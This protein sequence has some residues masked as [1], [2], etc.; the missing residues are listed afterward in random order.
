MR[1]PIGFCLLACKSLACS[2]LLSFPESVVVANL[3]W[4]VPEP[5]RPRAESL[6]V[7]AEILDAAGATVASLRVPYAPLPSTAPWPDVEP[8]MTIVFTDVPSGASRSVRASLREGESPTA[9]ACCVGESP[10]FD[11]SQ[12]GADVRVSLGWLPP[13]APDLTRIT[14]E[15]APWGT[16][17]AGGVPGSP[18]YRVVGSA[19]AAPPG[20]E[21]VVYNARDVAGG[22]VLGRGPVDESGAF[23]VSLGQQKFDRPELARVGTARGRLH[24]DISDAPGIQVGRVRRVRWSATLGEKVPG[25]SSPNPHRLIARRVTTAARQPP[26][27]ER[28]PSQEEIQAAAAT[29]GTSATTSS[30]RRWKRVDLSSRPAPFAGRSATFDPVRDVTVLWGGAALNLT[31]GV[32]PRFA[33]GGDRVWEWD[34]HSLTPILP[35]DS[36][37]AERSGHAMS[38]DGARGE[39]IMHGG[40]GLDGRLLG[41]LWSWDGRRWTEVEQGGDV[42]PPLFF[43]TMLYDSIRGEV[44]LF[45]GA[46]EI[47][48]GQFTEEV[49]RD[50]YVL[51][52]G[53]WARVARDQGP[54]LASVAATFDRSAGLVYAI[55]GLPSTDPY[56][57]FGPEEVTRSETLWSW[58]GSS[59]SGVHGVD[60]PSLRTGGHLHPLSDG[61]LLFVGGLGSSDLL[62][63]PVLMWRWDS[64]TASWTALSAPEGP[65]PRAFA[66]SAFH[67][68]RNQILLVGGATLG[69]V[70]EGL[71]ASQTFDDAWVWKGE[72]WSRVYGEDGAGAPPARAGHALVYDQAEQEISMLG[73]CRAY[74]CTDPLDDVWRWNGFRWSRTATL[75]EAV[76]LATAV[77]DERG[78]WVLGGERRGRDPA[79]NVL[80]PGPLQRL[81][82]GAARVIDGPELPVGAAA[83]N[84]PTSSSALVFGGYLGEGTTSHLRRLS[85][86]DGTLETLSSA[87]GPAARWLHGGAYE[88]ESSSFVIVGGID[89]T[90]GLSELIEGFGY[91]DAWRWTLDQGWHP[92]P[93]PSPEARLGATMAYHPSDQLLYLFG[94]AYRGESDVT[95]ILSGQLWALEGDEWTRLDDRDQGPSPRVSSPLV[96]D[97]RTGDL[98]LFG[99]LFFTA[100]QGTIVSD[101]TWVIDAADELRPHFQFEADVAS[102]A[103]DDL[104]IESIQLHVRAAGQ[105]PGEDGFLLE[106]WDHPT[107]AWQEIFAGGGRDLQ[108]VEVESSSPEEARRWAPGRKAFLRILPRSTGARA[109]VTLDAVEMVVLFRIAE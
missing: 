34:G 27:I 96:Y 74:P 53:R 84:V 42:P 5:E 37:P 98:V 80:P 1:A 18:V 23:V 50:T 64:R 101:D 59:W 58:D 88:P 43:H 47:S 32:E 104:V 99:G 30:S 33:S 62:G 2:S 100:R 75:S 56:F 6:W 109:T 16:L 54:Q 49:H 20:A 36:R 17:G 79:G 94:G 108:D 8:D 82:G 92:L 66:A 38:F 71:G 60:A 19:G 68:T 81:E 39:V 63:E 52:E 21:A 93:S 90:P 55:G 31:L 44:V 15:V 12:D 87:G 103:L 24:S 78:L 85:L 26:V 9:A 76:G 102:A 77:S 22:V 107:G 86:P 72:R 10:P 14:Y 4:T 57:G 65:E 83:A 46:T 28:E 11:L 105:A 70:P 73:G 41:D 35:L 106:V 3:V 7:H 97:E 95:A 89:S 61:Q 29:G 13:A 40:I 67:P 45:G 48:I 51:R 69:L 91:D 25:S